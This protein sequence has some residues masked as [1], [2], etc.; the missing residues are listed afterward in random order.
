MESG[1]NVVSEGTG[2][3]KS[4]LAKY[5]N[6]GSTKNMIPDLSPLWVTETTTLLQQHCT[7]TDFF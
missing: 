6:P 7:A 5:Y 4:R 1:L 3:C 2:D